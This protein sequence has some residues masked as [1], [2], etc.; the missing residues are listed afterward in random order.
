VHELSLREDLLEQVGAIAR[1]HGAERVAS[2]TVRIGPLSG[3]EPMLLES[4]FTIGR[5]GTLAEQA[6]LRMEQQPVRVVCRSCEAESLAGV[7]DL[8][9][10]SC[11]SYDTELLSGDELILASVE[12]LNAD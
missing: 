12:L 9:C 8:V 2:I 10:P 11:G 6:E 3:I 1:A 5:V 7:S 4:A